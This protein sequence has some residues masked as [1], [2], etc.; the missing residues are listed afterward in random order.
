MK[1]SDILSIDNVLTK[2]INEVVDLEN[3]EYTSIRAFNKNTFKL[4]FNFY[5][6]NNAIAYVSY[7]VTEDD[8]NQTKLKFETKIVSEDVDFWNVVEPKSWFDFIKSENHVKLLKML[9]KIAEESKN[10]GE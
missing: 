10:S 1:I 7:E 6:K 5:F 9:L 2:N 4:N 3:Y 8:D